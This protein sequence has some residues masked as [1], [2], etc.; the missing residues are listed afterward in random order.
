[1]PQNPYHK[2]NG[3]VLVG[4]CSGSASIG[5]YLTCIL[6]KPNSNGR[7]ESNYHVKLTQP[8]PAVRYWVG[9][10]QVFIQLKNTI[11]YENRLVKMIH[12]DLES[13]EEEKREENPGRARGQNSAQDVLV[14][15]G[16]L[17]MQPQGIPVPVMPPLDVSQEPLI[18][19]QSQQPFP[20]PVSENNNIGD[21]QL[22]NNVNQQ[23]VNHGN[24]L[25]ANNGNQLVLRGNNTVANVPAQSTFTAESYVAATF[26]PKVIGD[27]KIF[28]EV[29]LSKFVA[30]NKRLGSTALGKKID[31]PQ[32]TCDKYLRFIMCLINKNVV[33]S[34][35]DLH[36]SLGEFSK[37]VLGYGNYGLVTA[38]SNNKYGDMT[39]AQVRQLL[40]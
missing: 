6:W 32:S 27:Y 37:N 3:M 26:Y 39:I 31:M 18:Q 19:Q 5:G 30:A 2:G 1:M 36:Q 16:A 12:D 9:R 28:A 23:M 34:N 24:H 33:F 13:Q 11:D 7:N 29:I 25:M 10:V 20:P 38:G 35:I 40:S 21:Q 14:Y 15:N 17:P 22:V 4:K 8:D